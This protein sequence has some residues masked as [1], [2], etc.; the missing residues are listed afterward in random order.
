MKRVLGESI[1]LVRVLA[2]FCLSS[3]FSSFAFKAEG[4][5]YYMLLLEKR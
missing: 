3:L 4:T 2:W 5:S 1:Y